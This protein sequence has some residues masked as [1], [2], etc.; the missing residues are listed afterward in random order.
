MV[1]DRPA[2]ESRQ[3]MTDREIVAAVRF[4]AWALMLAKVM[5]IANVV[6]RYDMTKPLRAQIAWLDSHLSV[7]LWGLVLTSGG[8]TL[9]QFYWWLAEVAG[10]AGRVDLRRAFGAW[11]IITVS[12]YMIVFAGV[13]MTTSGWLSQYFGRWWPAAGAAIVSGLL[14]VGALGA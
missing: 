6:L 8:W 11:S 13:V 14:I 10:T 12:F 1:Q 4:T 2:A 3:Q 9:H 7:V 5:I